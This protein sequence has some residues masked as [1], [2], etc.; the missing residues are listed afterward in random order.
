MQINN[1]APGKQFI[2][3]PYPGTYTPPELHFN[4]Y[5]RGVATQRPNS[6]K[7]RNLKRPALDLRTPEPVPKQFLEQPGSADAGKAFFSKDIHNQI[8]KRDQSNAPSVTHNANFDALKFEPEF[9]FSED[10]LEK[11]L[12]DS[13]I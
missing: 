11:K 8:L 1:S 10:E 12:M 3:N 4:T 13:E 9:D 6:F 2:T 7:A 5:D